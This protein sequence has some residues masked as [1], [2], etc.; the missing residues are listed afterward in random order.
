M[1]AKTTRKP[2]FYSAPRGSFALRPT[3]PPAPRRSARRRRLPS[4]PH[5]HKLGAPRCAGA[6]RYRRSRAAKPFCH[7]AQQFLV[8]LAVDRRG[9]QLRRP[10]AI[11]CLRQ[12]RNAGPRLDPDLK[13]D[14]AHP[15]GRSRH[16][17]KRPPA[18]PSG[19]RR[20]VDFPAPVPQRQS[21]PPACSPPAR[22]GHPPTARSGPTKRAG[23]ADVSANRP[24]R[25]QKTLG[26]DSGIEKTRGF[27]AIASS[28]Y[29][30]RVPSRMRPRAA[31]VS[32]DA[33]LAPR[34]GKAP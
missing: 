22:P 21:R 24:L 15:S 10:A 29:Q 3:R 4:R 14:V 18:W 34:P 9:L 13:R 11:V 8:G 12:Q 6:N 19:S 32:K 20:P 27:A 23:R 7:Q 31:R 30:A 2:A 17:L 26:P 33:R 5:P 16:S 28:S 25:Q 1:V